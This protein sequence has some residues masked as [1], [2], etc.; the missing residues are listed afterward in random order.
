VVSH[1]QASLAIAF[2]R[3]VMR[4]HANAEAPYG[5]PDVTDPIR[6]NFGE[7]SGLRWLSNAL[8]VARPILVLRSKRAIIL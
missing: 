3:P 1:V 2:R 8:A 6:C 5:L 4:V 7:W